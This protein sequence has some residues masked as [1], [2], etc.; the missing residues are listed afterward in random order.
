MYI[1]HK[2]GDSCIKTKLKC[3][4]QFSLRVSLIFFIIVSLVILLM[5][6]P[7]SLLLSVLPF[8]VVVFVLMFLVPKPSYF[9]LCENSKMVVEFSKGDVTLH[10][11][12]PFVMR[13]D[14]QHLVSELESSIIFLRECWNMDTMMISTPAFCDTSGKPRKRICFLAERII[15]KSKAKEIRSRVVKKPWFNFS[16]LV[17]ILKIIPRRLWY[18]NARYFYEIN[19]RF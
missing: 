9:S 15:E 8:V 3:S 13:S 1:V 4:L 5:N 16:R 7:L 12:D 14:K 10:L 18:V 17:L 2:K 6:W 11:R 19:A